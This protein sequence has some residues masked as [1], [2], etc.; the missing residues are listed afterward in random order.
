MVSATGSG[1]LLFTPRIGSLY[2]YELLWALL[3]AVA[4]KWVVN[5]EVG[6]YT[7]VTGRT[8][9]EGYGGVPG[10]RRW[11]VWLILVPQLLVAVAALAA[12]AGAAATA[13]V[14]ALPGGLRLW[15]IVVLS[16]A[17]ALAFG[18]RFSVVERAAKV[19]A[20]LL[21]V[22]AVVAALRVAPDPGALAAGLRPAIPRGA[23]PGEAL[24]WLGFA[25]SGAAGMVWYSYWMRSKGY[26]AAGAASA[27]GALAGRSAPAELSDA[28]RR[29]LQGWVRQMTLDNTVAVVGALIILLAFL[30]LG[31]ELLRP[32]GLLPE[33]NRVAEVLGRLLGGV[34]GQ[35]GFWGMIVALCVGFWTTVLS[36]QDGFARMFTDG[37]RVVAGKASLR[38]RWLDETRLRRLYVVGLLA[39]LP[40]VLYLIAG[41]PV[42]LLKAAGAVEAAHIPVIALCTVYLNRR[43]PD[44]LR[45]SWGIV[46]LALLAAL[47]FAAF[48]AVYAYRLLGGGG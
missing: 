17:A 45:P 10:P 35:V 19:V 6:R 25:L 18:G 44:G 34:F 37:T 26:G 4:L 2:G 20:A 29:R 8:L 32:R 24:P 12:L 36:D 22:A 1:E 33:E 38:S 5:R 43:L 27:K 3:A 30:V 39:V 28:D 16:L 41:E 15:A 42:V 11:A 9:L 13:L 21:G 31:A 47:F 46:A 40:I 14:V 23:D 48:A 7:V